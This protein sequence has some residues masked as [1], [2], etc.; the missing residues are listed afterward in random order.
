MAGP[1]L[2]P[3]RRWLLD[4]GSLTQHLVNT[5]RRFSVERWRQHWADVSLDERRFLGMGLRER[6]MVRQVILRLDGEAV[7]YARSVF[8]ARSLKGPLL[9][10]RRLAHQS[11]GAFLF[12]RPDMRRSPFELALLE[13]NDPYLPAE[14]R[15]GTPAWARRSCFV[16]AGKPLLVSEV[17][18]EGFRG[19]PAVMPLHRSRRGRVDATIGGSLFQASVP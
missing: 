15:Q 19:W 1:L 5:G 12:G 13:G 17:F 11:L 8:P 2:S 16:V 14:L 6:G 3:V 9:H 4:D 10:L 7:V 18:L